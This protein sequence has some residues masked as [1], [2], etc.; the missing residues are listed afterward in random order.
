MPKNLDS[1]HRRIQKLR[2]QGSFSGQEWGFVYFL[3]LIAGCSRKTVEGILTRFAFTKNERAAIRQS[4]KISSI[5]KKL[6]ASDVSP[7]QVFKILRVLTEETV[8]YLWV[9]SLSPVAARRIERFVSCDRHVA[10]SIGGDDLKA[11]GIAS[12]NAMGRIL[13]DILCLKIDKKIRTKQEELRAASA[14]SGWLRS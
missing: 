12:G 3:A 4:L 5:L 11:M 7:S 8:L 13:E 10:L 9:L 1:L 2:R 6:S 14:C